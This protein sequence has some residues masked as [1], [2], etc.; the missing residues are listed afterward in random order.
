MQIVDWDMLD[1]Q[2][3][4]QA[5]ARPAAVSDEKVRVAVSGILE[6][7]RT[8]GD[9]AVL[10]FTEKFDGVRPVPYRISRKDMQA[11]WDA[12]PQ[13][14]KRAL[15]TAIDNVSAFHAAQKPPTI[16]VETMSG[17]LCRREVR[18]LSRVGLYVP[19][20]TAPLVSTL[21][22]LAV[23]AKIAGVGERIVVTPPSE[24]GQINRFI[25]AAASRCE[26]TDMF[27]VGGAQ[28]IAA[29][30]F[31][32]ETIAK[33]DKIFGPGNAY[34][35]EA[36]SQM[37]ARPGGPALDLPAGPSEVMVLADDSAD[38]EF[39]AAD[40]LSQAEHDK[41]A[42]VMCMCTSRALAEAIKA[43]TL[44]Q[45]A[46][47][48]R[49]QIAQASL[50]HARLIVAAR[51]DMADIVND[52]APEHLIVQ[53]ERPDAIVP[54][55]TNAGSIFIGPWTPEAVGDYASGTNHTLPTDGAAR[56]WSGLTLDSFLKYI[57]VQKLSRAGLEVLGPTV[58][59][60]ADM[61]GLDAH[62]RAVS[63]RLAEGNS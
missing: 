18:P 28:A 39:V 57:S 56:A 40:L 55:I 26:V 48:P 47:L 42:Q 34:V 29:L 37:A 25:L 30:G 63:C 22:M 13:R 38:P 44:R 14:D 53:L 46:D 19:G 15:Q 50:D 24:D 2:G 7:V 4:A 12:L 41:A 9:A 17:V 21:I 35:A 20:G 16:E 27:A 61:E 31:G 45:L 32:T 8:G 54:D 6:A 52:Y 62:R 59:R 23:P 49:R 58:E 5:L 10:G 33:C 36:K 43:A 11:A 51:A 1:G 3:R 60:L